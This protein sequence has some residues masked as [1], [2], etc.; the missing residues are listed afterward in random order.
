MSQQ[1]VAAA[2]LS[3][4]RREHP[5]RFKASTKAGLSDKPLAEEILGDT[6]AISVIPDEFRAEEAFG[7]ESFFKGAANALV[8]FVGGGTPFEQQA[9]A[10][11]V[12]NEMSARTQ[13]VLRADV[14][15][16]RI[17]LVVQE[18]LARYAEDP[19]QLF[20]GDELGRQNLTSTVTALSRALQRTKDQINSPTK[21]TPTKIGKLE[22]ALFAL[23][24]LVED[25][26]RVLASI[27]RTNGPAPT[28]SRI[29]PTAT[30]VQTKGGGSF[31]LEP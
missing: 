8:D 14:P 23:T 21:K 31:I 22:D 26:T 30:P 24:D 13:I 6:G 16:G 2:K 7:A 28:D 20:R 25:Y 17:P 5:D 9:K 18:L 11:T 27:E 4:E 10:Q 1:R 15:G 29:T 19:T 12:L 3:D